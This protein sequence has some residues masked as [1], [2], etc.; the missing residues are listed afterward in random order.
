MVKDEA[1]NHHVEEKLTDIMYMFDDIPYIDSS[2]KYD[3][4][5]VEIDVD[6]SKQLVAHV[7]E[8]ELQL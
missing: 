7:W 1:Q 2:P 3:E 5:I 6:Y 4:V 8:E